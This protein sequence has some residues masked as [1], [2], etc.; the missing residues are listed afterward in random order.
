MNG[1]NSVNMKISHVLLTSNMKSKETYK[2][3]PRPKNIEK[4]HFYFRNTR[5]TFE[6]EISTNNF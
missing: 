1:K 2:Y 4:S 5:Q 6:H 3:V